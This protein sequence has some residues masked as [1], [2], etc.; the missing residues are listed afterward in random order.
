VG[1]VAKPDWFRVALAHAVT[2]CRPA[3]HWAACQGVSFTMDTAGG[4]RVRRGAPTCKAHTQARLRAGNTGSRGRDTQTHTQAET[5]THHTRTRSGARR[6]AV[7][8]V[9]LHATGRV[10]CGGV[11]VVC[12]L[13]P[14]VEDAHHAVAIGDGHRCST[15]ACRVRVDAGSV[16][17]Q[18]AGV[19]VW[20]GGA[21][22]RHSATVTGGRAM[23]HQT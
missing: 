2:A 21:N 10:E 8:Q 7:A 1:W 4:W 6:W 14:A 13:R 16:T 5:H 12:E 20:G 22:G 18:E 11:K 15:T 23:M 3:R 19:G 9:V 17:R